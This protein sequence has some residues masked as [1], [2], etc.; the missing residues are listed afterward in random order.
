MPTDQPTVEIRKDAQEHVL[1]LRQTPQ[2]ESIRELYEAAI[3]L[4]ETAT[5]VVVDCEGI[6]HIGGSA[7]QILLALQTA[8]AGS[9]GTI[10]LRGITPRIAQYLAVAG[11]SDHLPQTGLEGNSCPRQ[12]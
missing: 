4:A 11:V 1:T 10:A 8:L 12:C 6:E 3:S 9:G 7:L 5:R 2:L